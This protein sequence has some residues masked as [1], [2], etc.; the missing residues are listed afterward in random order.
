MPSIMA[1]AGLVVEVEVCTCRQ[2][3]RG[4]FEEKVG[5]ERPRR[6]ERRPEMGAYDAHA[7]LTGLAVEVDVI[8][9]VRG[10]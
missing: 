6:R 4:E 10:S 1:S 2:D 3:D 7:L 5:L 9:I 8:W